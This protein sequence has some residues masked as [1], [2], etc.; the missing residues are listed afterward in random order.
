MKEWA[1][2]WLDGERA[3]GVKRLEIKMKGDNH[4]VYDSTTHWDKN[5]KKA[6]KTSKYLGK[7]DRDKGLILSRTKRLAQMKSVPAVE[8]DPATKIISL[9]EKSPSLNAEPISNAAEIQEK[10][11]S[12]EEYGN[13][14][15]IDKAMEDLKPILKDAFPDDWREIYAVAKIRICGNVPLKRVKTSWEKLCDAESLKP[16]LNPESVSN[17]LHTVGVDRIGQDTV[18]R[19]LLDHSE[20]LIMT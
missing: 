17:L 13:S 8:T 12:V 10:L 19:H 4:Y 5:L 20:Q 3:K 14:I 6:V 2:K 15:L 1:K 18:F 9:P 7:L 16:N 11:R